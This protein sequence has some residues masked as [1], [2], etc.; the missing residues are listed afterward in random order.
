MPKKLH[1][2]LTSHANA[3][4]SRCITNQERGTCYNDMRKA[5]TTNI[6]YK[7]NS[8]QILTICEKI[9]EIPMFNGILLRS[10]P[11]ERTKH[12]FR[13]VVHFSGIFLNG[14]IEDAIKFKGIV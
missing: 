12:T 2:Q 5:R 7:K 3:S 11:D 6:F 4:F 8:R 1:N 10:V 9:A 14:A 13:M